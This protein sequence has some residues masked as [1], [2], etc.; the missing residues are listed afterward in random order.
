[1]TVMY[2]HGCLME[3]AVAVSFGTQ[4]FSGVGDC[5]IQAKDTRDFLSPGETTTFSV[6]AGSVT[7][8][9]GK[10]FCYTVSVCGEIG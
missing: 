4:P 6:N 1:M 3:C 8:E 9:S 7:R 2:N 5:A 10:V